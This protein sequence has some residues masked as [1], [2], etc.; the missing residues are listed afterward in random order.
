MIST[1]PFSTKEHSLSKV[2]GM[3]VQA[4]AKER[5]HSLSTPNLRSPDERKSRFVGVV[6]DGSSIRHCNGGRC[7]NW[8]RSR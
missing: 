4:A 8:L 5:S 1:A 3:V 6:A 7:S 2:L